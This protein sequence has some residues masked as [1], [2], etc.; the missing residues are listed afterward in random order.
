MPSLFS[1]GRS[2][3]AQPVSN[4]AT[5]PLPNPVESGNGQARE[6]TIFM[7]IDSSEHCNRAF[8]WYLDNVKRTGDKLCFVHV[9]EPAF[10]GASAVALSMEALPMLIG[11]TRLS[12]EDGIGQGRSVLKNFMAEA[13]SHQ[14]NTNAMVYVN[15]R[16]GFTIVDCAKENNA[17]LIVMGNRGLGTMSRTFLGSVSDYVLHHANIPVLIVPPKQN[18]K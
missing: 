12:V 5:T 4:P 9:V 16:P 8:H 1:F 14:V 2:E 13:K 3:P 6:R 10:T 11:D 18:K 7:P 15:N 17:D